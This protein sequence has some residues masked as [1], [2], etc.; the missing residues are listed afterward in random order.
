MIVVDESSAVGRHAAS[1]SRDS[2][3]VCDHIGLPQFGSKD[4]SDEDLFGLSLDNDVKA[5][6]VEGLPPMT[7]F[8]HSSD[9]VYSF[10]QSR[11]SVSANFR[12]VDSRAE[13]STTTMCS[14]SN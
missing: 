5:N 2:V 7:F 9:K 1:P 10:S 4:V 11:K 3:D 13:R 8:S 12:N 6:Q 14:A